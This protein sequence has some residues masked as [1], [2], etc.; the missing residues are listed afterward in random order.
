MSDKKKQAKERPAEKVEGKVNIR[1][2]MCFIV[3]GYK[4]GDTKCKHCGARIYLIDSA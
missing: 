3:D 1:C 4:T 2:R